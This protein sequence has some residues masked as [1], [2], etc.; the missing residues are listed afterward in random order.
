MSCKNSP[1]DFPSSYDLHEGQEIHSRVRQHRGGAPFTGLATSRR[2]SVVGFLTAADTRA[3]MARGAGVRH[4]LD[5]RTTRMG[6]ISQGG[7]GRRHRWPGEALGR[8]LHGRSGV[9]GYRAA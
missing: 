1:L 5:G 4:L 8:E 7:E 9:A 2:R 6:W 3:S